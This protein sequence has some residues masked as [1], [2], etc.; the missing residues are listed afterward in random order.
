MRYVIQVTE[1]KQTVK[2][3]EPVWSAIGKRRFSLE[4]ARNEYWK[5]VNTDLGEP[6][7][8]RIFDTKT[9]EAVQ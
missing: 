4:G 9:N 3:N 7:I 1:L 6:L 8:Y 5:W 2:G